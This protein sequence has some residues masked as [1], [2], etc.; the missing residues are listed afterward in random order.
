MKMRNN[1]NSC[2]ASSFNQLLLVLGQECEADHKRSSTSCFVLCRTWTLVNQLIA[3]GITYRPFECMP[4]DILMD[5][6][7]RE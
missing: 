7:V 4:K 1:E 2:H 6:M 5:C 3:K